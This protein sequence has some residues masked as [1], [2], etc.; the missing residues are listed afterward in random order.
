MAPLPTALI[1]VGIILPT[2][3]QARHPDVARLFFIHRS[4]VKD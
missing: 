4:A 1:A 3:Q 2:K